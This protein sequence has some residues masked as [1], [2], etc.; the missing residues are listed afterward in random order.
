[1]RAII[2]RRVDGSR[3]SGIQ[4]F[5]VDLHCMPCKTWFWQ[6]MDSVSRLLGIYLYIL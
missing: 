1:M 4:V 3:C 2:V 6:P 5:F